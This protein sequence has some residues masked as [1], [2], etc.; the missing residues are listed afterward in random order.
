[1]RHPIGVA[2]RRSSPS[3]SP[4]HRLLDNSIRDAF[5]FQG[6]KNMCCL[7]TGF[8]LSQVTL[9]DLLRPLILTL[10]LIVY[11]QMPHQTLIRTERGRL[12]VRSAAPY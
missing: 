1:M 7:I 12:L 2:S 11:T 8:S 4:V 5:I 9:I 10:I 3:H 6:R